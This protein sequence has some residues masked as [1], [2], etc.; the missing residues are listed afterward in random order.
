MYWKRIALGLIFFVLFWI[1]L[2][3]VL[4]VLGDLLASGGLPPQLKPLGKILA[5]LGFAFG[6]ISASYMIIDGGGGPMFCCPPKKLVKCGTF[7]MCRHPVYLGFM[8]FTLGLALEH[9]GIG[10]LVVVLLFSALV[11]F[12]TLLV[13]EK[14]LRKK[15]P[16]YSDY[17][18]KVPAFIPKKPS[19]SETCPPL[20]FMLLFYVGHIVSWFTWHIEVEKRCEPPEEGFVALANH[21]T[22]LDFAVVVYAIS[23][24]MNFP[25]SAFHYE[26]SKWL[27]RNVG[28][29]P[30]TRHKPDVRAIMKI[31]SLIRKGG[32]VGIFPEAERSWDG[33]FLGFKK[34]FDK[35]LAKLP[36]P[37]VAVRIENAQLRFPRWGKVFHPGKVKAIV[38]C[39]EDPA[40]VEEF[41]SKPSVPEDGVYDSYV[42]VENYIY[43]CPNCGKIGS[44]V[45]F[46]EGF[47]CENC[48]FEKI[49][50]KVGELWKMHDSL[51]DKIELPHV[52]KAQLVD[53][54]GRSIGDE[55]EV[56]FEKDGLEYRGRFIPRESFI[57]FI[58][59][60]KHEVFLY[61]GKEIHGF[62]FEK[63]ALLW[64]D[65]I[66]AYWK[67]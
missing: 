66:K 48:G 63:S 60:G 47:R 30:I 3:L 11:V 32:R 5:G 17:S 12:W 18:R 64:N 15:F 43:A 53:P 50:P 40:E 62:R 6:M 14:K 21:A 41:L 2:P 20:L 31:I 56:K 38:D 26:R 61:D 45:S 52:E 37:F 13:E 55:V 39:F 28:C 27:Y 65:L 4:L 44:I 57:S 42:G 36:K 9:G 8:V 25:V 23:R 1:F 51:L 7:S 49:K 58:V 67:L 35:L 46:R 10:S 54:Y 24:F 34:G 16:E 19:K 22:Y 59:E 33:R 29:F